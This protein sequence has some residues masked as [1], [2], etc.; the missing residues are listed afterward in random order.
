MTGARGNMLVNMRLTFE[1]M[2]FQ[3]PW[4][5]PLSL[6]VFVHGLRHNACENGH[7]LA[8]N[9]LLDSGARQ[10]NTMEGECLGCGTGRRNAKN[11]VAARCLVKTK[12]EEDLPT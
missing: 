1:A 9:A 6:T 8:V 5:L 7:L 10:L 12:M 3:D 11:M 4:C 2:F